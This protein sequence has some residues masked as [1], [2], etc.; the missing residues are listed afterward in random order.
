MQT[1]TFKKQQPPILI[2]T[3]KMAKKAKKGKYTLIITEK[4]NA[5]KRIA[6]ALADKTPVKKNIGQVPYYEITHDGKP[7]VVACAVGHLYG[8]KEKTKTK[9]FQYPVFDIEWTPSA[10][11]SKGAAFSKKYLTVLKKLAKDADSFIIATDFD[12]EG[13]VIGFNCLRFACKEKDAKRMKFS[14]LTKQ[15]LKK[16]F[17]NVRPHIEWGMANAGEARHKVDWFYGINLSRALSSSILKSGMFKILS[18][19]RV[20]GPALKIVVDKEKEIQSFKPVPFWQIELLCKKSRKNIQAWHEADK[21]WDKKK[22]DQVIKNTKT[23]KI[24]AVHKLQ[25]TKK[26]TQPPHPF[27]LTTLQTESHKC[28]HISPKNTLAIAQDLYT[29]GLISYPRTSSQQ[30]PPSIGYKKIMDLLCKNPDY[31]K[32]I[33]TLKGD[34]KPNNGKKTDPAHPAIYPTGIKPKEMDKKQAGVYDLI[35]KR[36]LATFSVP[37]VRATN[38]IYL[39]VKDEMFVAKGTRTVEQGW[40]DIYAPYVKLEEKELPVLEESEKLDI[41]KITLHDKETQPPKRYTE[42]SII[43]ELE[44]RNLGTKATRAQIVDTLQKRHY[45]EG[46]PL[47]AT[48][49]GIKTVDIL[50]KYS[51]KILDEKLTRHIEEEMELIQ[52]SKKDKEKMLKEVKEILL[53]LLKDFQKNEDKIGDGLQSTY[54]ETRTAQSTVGA[55]NNCEEGTLMM[56]KGKFGRFV[57]CDKYPDCKTTYSLPNTGLIKSTED[58]CEHCRLPIV[59]IFVKG[60]KPQMVCINP[61]CPSKNVE[62]EKVKD[63]GKEC[64][65]CKSGKLVLRKSVYGAFLACNKFPKCRYTQNLEQKEVKEAAKPKA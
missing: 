25:E 51:P 57:A 27:D 35:V 14:T 46:K 50:E 29:R 42:S 22:A 1:A 16:S 58:Q 20:Q 26:K 48:E 60:K 44:S 62:G 21:F 19:G 34:L 15:D 10:D 59:Q 23:E 33:S 17:E 37:A 18:I 65:K 47:H 41:K 12:I 40:F 43:K 49:L 6:A 28:L 52:E 64:P 36:F 4:P 54:K 31:A 56:R 7:Y 13:E 8:L 63:E 45:I 38:K 2:N 11:V 39:K 24:A 3:C 53:K 5:S 9:N 61:K 55:C 30:L 32:L